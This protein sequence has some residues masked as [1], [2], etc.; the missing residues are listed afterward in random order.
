MLDSITWEG[1]LWILFASMPI[2]GL[3]VVLVASFFLEIKHPKPKPKDAQ[4]TPAPDA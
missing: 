3:S 2:I 4:P 1:V